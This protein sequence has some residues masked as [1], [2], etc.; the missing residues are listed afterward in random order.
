[1][2][3]RVLKAG[4]SLHSDTSLSQISNHTELLMKRI[5]RFKHEAFC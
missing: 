3:N 4:K 1:M 2:D 5:R